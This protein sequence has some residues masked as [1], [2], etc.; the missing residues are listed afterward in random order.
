MRLAAIH[1]HPVKALGF[2]ELGRTV[3]TAGGTLPWDRRWAVAHEAAKLDGDGWAPCANFS[4]GASSPAAD[5]GD[6]SAT[7]RHP[8]A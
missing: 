3:L 4:R 1:R 6:G 8:A 2:E 5:G 7:T